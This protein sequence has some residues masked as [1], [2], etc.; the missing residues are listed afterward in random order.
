MSWRS[1]EEERERGGEGD[2]ALAD[3]RGAVAVWAWLAE[4]AMEMREWRQPRREQEE[5]RCWRRADLKGGK[6]WQGEG[7]RVKRERR[8]DRGRGEWDGERWGRGIVGGGRA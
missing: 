4:R 1:R 8:G 7:G 5:V 3:N 2:C 6:G